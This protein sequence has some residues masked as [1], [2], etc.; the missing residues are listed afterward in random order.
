MLWFLPKNQLQ[1]W[2]VYIS[3]WTPA[4]GIWEKLGLLIKLSASADPG[5]TVWHPVFLISNHVYPWGSCQD[6]Y[7]FVSF[8]ICSHEIWYSN[9][10]QPCFL[11]YI[12][13]NV[14]LGHSHPVSAASP[15]CCHLQSM[16]FFLLGFPK[17]HTFALTSDNR[18]GSADEDF[19]FLLEWDPLGVVF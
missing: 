7:Y 11:I 19:Y 5:L 3:L 13:M 16:Y 6:K 4:R 15:Q 1:P 8:N 18:D 14:P 12:V 9:S 2:V 17:Q 10:P